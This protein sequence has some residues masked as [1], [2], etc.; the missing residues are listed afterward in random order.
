M[1]TVATHPGD[2]AKKAKLIWCM[3]GQP[4]MHIGLHYVEQI[5]EYAV[6]N[7]C[8]VLAGEDKHRDYKNLVQRTNHRDV[9]KTLLLQESFRRTLQLV[10][11]E[12]SK[13]ICA[14]CPALF[15]NLLRMNQEEA[16]EDDDSPNYSGMLEPTKDRISPKIFGR[17]S[18]S[19]KSGKVVIQFTNLSKLELLHPFVNKLREAYDVDWNKPS[20]LEPEHRPILFYNKL[21]FSV[22]DRVRRISLMEG[23]IIQYRGAELGRITAIFVHEMG[24]VKQIFFTLI[25]VHLVMHDRLLNLP[26]LQ[27]NSNNYTIVGLPSVQK[28]A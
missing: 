27:D 21:T 25:P 3:K 6:S 7:N 9:E 11:G 26:I 10:L 18:S 1:G 12:D 20:V 16:D 17:L 14:V 24:G 19:K 15:N 23:D 28:A 4:N 2:Y 8:N 22:W 5:K 13:A